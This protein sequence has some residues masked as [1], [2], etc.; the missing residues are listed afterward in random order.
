MLPRA[1]RRDSD[2]HS[3]S[4][5]A[6]ALIPLLVTVNQAAQL[7][8]IGRTTVYELIEA[9][10]LRS[11][12]RGSSRRI[13]LKAIHDYMT[14]SSKAP[15][16]VATR[17]GLSHPIRSLARLDQ[18]TAIAATLANALSAGTRRIEDGTYRATPDKRWWIAL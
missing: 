6:S 17:E 2:T 4:Q 1:D 15:S 11:A 10:E 9:G 13:P 8:G 16:V 5:I 18:A 12:K 14:V 7:L 3:H